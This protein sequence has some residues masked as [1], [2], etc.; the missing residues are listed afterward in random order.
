MALVQA[1]D[2]RLYFELQ[3]HLE[4]S[5]REYFVY[6]FV[7]EESIIESNCLREVSADQLQWQTKNIMSDIDPRLGS[8]RLQ[9][10]RAG[11][12][13]TMTSS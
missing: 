12:E 13:K 7:R 8:L 4:L 1:S 3:Y 5:R 10:A 2:V 6:H 11:R 9:I